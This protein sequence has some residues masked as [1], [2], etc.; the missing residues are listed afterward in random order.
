MEGRRLMVAHDVQSVARDFRVAV[1]TCHDFGWETVVALHGTPGVEVVG[2]V[3]APLPSPPLKSRL[4]RVWQRD[5][6]VG[7]ALAIA[8]VIGRAISARHGGAVGTS[9]ASSQAVRRVEG[10]PEFRLPALDGAEC[11]S[12]LRSLELDLAILDGTNI[13]KPA[14]FDIPRLGSINLHCGRLPEY[15]GAPPAF[16]EL[17]NGELEVGVTVHRVSAALDAGDILAESSCPL[18]PAPAGDPVMYANRV[19]RESLRPSGL[20]LIERVTRALAS[21]QAIARPQPA[22]TRAPNRIPSRAQERRLREV[23]AARRRET[24]PGA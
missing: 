21:G 9:E 18:D 19:W 12:L 3:R 11:Q 20:Q 13:L 5:G 22:T 14:T 15:R 6:G 17:M 4:R 23:V 8:R 24:G 2:L 1:L 16:W 10:V 7:V